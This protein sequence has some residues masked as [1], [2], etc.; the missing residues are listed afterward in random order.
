[1]I[2]LLLDKCLGI[3]RV[4]AIANGSAT[5]GTQQGALMRSCVDDLLRFR[6]IQHVVG[7]VDFCGCVINVGPD[8]L[9]PR[10]ETA[11]MVTMI[12]EAWDANPPS[13]VV[14]VCT[15]SG[16][17]AVSL[18]KRFPQSRVSAMELSPK[19]LERASANAVLNKVEVEF[20]AA[21]VLEPTV[22]ISRHKVDLIVSNP[23]YICESER[24]FMQPNVLDYEPDMALFVPDD[25]PLLFYRAILQKSLPC[26]SDR[27]E[28][29]FEMNETK[30]PEMSDLCVE[31]GFSAEFYS[32]IN[33]KCRFC[34]AWLD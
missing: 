9:I 16:C 1:M 15:G 3:S 18:A 13:R 7:H 29:W 11:E 8:V 34:K 27:G 6:P 30:R 25:E 31:M 21:D 12:A 10:P 5:I 20:V 32:D 28:V 26:L 2:D 24:Q 14:D 17:V 33:G 23:P 19:A 4:D 22:A